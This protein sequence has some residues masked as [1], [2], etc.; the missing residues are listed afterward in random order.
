LVSPSRP[1]LRLLETAGCSFAVDLRPERGRES[2]RLGYGRDAEG[3]QTSENAS[4]RGGG[5]GC[6]LLIES[7]SRAVG[8]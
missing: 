3:R 7:S 4:W 6:K 5:T 2:V 8:V 1:A